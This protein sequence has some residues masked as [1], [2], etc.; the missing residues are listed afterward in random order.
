[1]PR[2][3]SSANGAVNN[4]PSRLSTALD[5][6]NWSGRSLAVLLGMNERTVRRWVSGAYEP[7]EPVLEWIE[8][9]ARVSSGSSAAV[10][11][12]VIVSISSG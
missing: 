3:L 1:M 5:A 7:P 12:P 11:L 10:R 9:L 4:I 2:L 8:E 6:L